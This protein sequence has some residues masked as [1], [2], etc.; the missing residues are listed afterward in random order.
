[1]KSL[2]NWGVVERAGHQHIITQHL[3]PTDI[4]DAKSLKAQTV[5]KCSKNNQERVSTEFDLCF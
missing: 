2:T 1:M 3:H 5:V 4:T